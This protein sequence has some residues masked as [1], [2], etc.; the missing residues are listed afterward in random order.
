MKYRRSQQ[1]GGSY[2]FTVVTHRRQTILSL[3]ENINRL[4]VAFKRE[5]EKHP[6]IIDAIV[7]LPDHLHTLW[8]LPEGDN[9]YSIRWSR[10]KRYFS[11]GCVGAVEQQSTSRHNKR[12]KPVWQRRF[13]EHTIRDENDWQR[14]MDYIH[15]NP[16]RHGHAQVPGEWPY[17]SFKRCVQKGWYSPNWGTTEPENIKGINC[18]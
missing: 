16:V 2:F 13:W 7:I 3:P 12:E 14:H 9:D 1:Q 4:R 18:E 10:I 5:M 15:Y 11:S 6:F 17:S 8:R